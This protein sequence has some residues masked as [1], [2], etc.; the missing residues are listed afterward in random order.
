MA[1]TA[2]RQLSWSLVRTRKSR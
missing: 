2:N 1:Y